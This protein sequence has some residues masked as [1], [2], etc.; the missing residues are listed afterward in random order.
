MSERELKRTE[1]FVDRIEGN[2]AV[3]RIQETTVELP[4]ALL[5]EGAG[6]GTW[7]DFSLAVIAAPEEIEQAEAT[8]RK[9]SSDDD[10]GDFKL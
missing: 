1:A 4:R 6:E 2:I 8:R 10:G 9:L 5:P 7:L 3:L